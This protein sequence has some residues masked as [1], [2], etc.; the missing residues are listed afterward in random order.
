[1]L[2][3]KGQIPLRYPVADQVAELVAD[4][5]VRVACVSQAG[6]KLL[7]KPAANRS[8]I[9]FELSR[10]V[11]IARTCLRPAFDP[12]SRELVADQHKVVGNLVG[13]WVCDQICDLYSVIE[14]GLK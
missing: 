12:K 14:F 8:T 3:D 6:R 1:M 7:K 5:R 10:H 11:E 9:N 13:N 2:F 4:L